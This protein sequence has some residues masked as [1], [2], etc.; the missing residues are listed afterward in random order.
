MH[1]DP[2]HPPSSP[3]LVPQVGL[4][5]YIH[6]FILINMYIYICI[7]MCVCVCVCVF[8]YVYSYVYINIHM[9]IYICMF[10]CV[11][12]YLYICMYIHICI[13]MWS[14]CTGYG[15]PSLFPTPTGIFLY[16]YLYAC[17]VYI[18]QFLFVWFFSLLMPYWLVYVIHVEDRFF[19]TFR[20]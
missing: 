6:V 13:L 2:G 11:C 20:L 12:V 1:R 3:P 16:I 14:L 5:M 17:T 19:N 18:R 7:F 8:I 4:Y 9:Y 15:A 10:M